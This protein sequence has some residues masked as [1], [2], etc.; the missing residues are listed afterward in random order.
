[1]STELSKMG[2]ILKNE[3]PNRHSFFQLKHFVVGKEP[4]IQGKMWQCLRE[5]RARADA[6]EN[7]DLEIETTKD[8]KILGDIELE[9]LEGQL[10]NAENNPSEAKNK[11]GRLRIEVKIRQTKRQL[12]A[13]DKK[14]ADLERRKKNTEEEATFFIQ[15]FETL[16]QSEPLKGFDDFEAQ[17]EYWG[18]KL[19]ENVLLRQIFRLPT[20]IEA[21]S[22]V[23]ALPD[24]ALIKKEIVYMINKMQD[25]QQ[26]QQ[27]E[28]TKVEVKKAED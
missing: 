16:N 24:E 8:N 23:L 21:I 28:A 17:T 10:Y 7:I 1:M 11:N 12:D 5:L 18:S 14:I 13:I 25:A 4:T 27:Q 19:K 6:L 9:E 15:A 20:E 22:T 2:D 26:Q 3:I